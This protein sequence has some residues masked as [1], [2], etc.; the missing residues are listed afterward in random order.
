[1]AHA[2]NLSLFRVSPACR[3]AFLTKILL[4]LDF[5]I[6]IPVVTMNCGNAGPQ[7]CVPN[8][9][10]LRNIADVPPVEP[11]VVTALIP[12]IPVA[13]ALTPQ[14]N[15]VTILISCYPLLR[16]ERTGMLLAYQPYYQ[17]LNTNNF[18]D[19][20]A[21]LRPEAAGPEHMSYNNQE[22]ELED[23]ATS[24]MK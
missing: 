17:Y 20:H 1:M 4:D 6:Y 5:H 15:L 16:D 9:Q 3:L 10:H 2:A 13:T 8:I 23:T 11:P 18:H 12:F 24:N 21:Q 7:H 22:N 19:E 14:G